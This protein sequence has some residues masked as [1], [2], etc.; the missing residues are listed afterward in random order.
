MYFLPYIHKYP[1]TTLFR[2]VFIFHLITMKKM[3]PFVDIQ[4]STNVITLNSKYLNISDLFVF[5]QLEKLEAETP[6]SCNNC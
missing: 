2:T 4:K 1:C 3:F 5:A 6:H